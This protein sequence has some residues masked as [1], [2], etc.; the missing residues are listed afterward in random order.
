MHKTILAAAAALGLVASAHAEPQEAWIYAG[1]QGGAMGWEASSIKR[2]E[3]AGTA[4][5][6][7]FFY[8]TKP[9]DGAKG[10]FSWAFQ[11][12][13]FDCVEN[14]FRLM[15]GAF[16]NK[17]RRGRSDQKASKDAFPVRD[18]TPEYVLKKVVCD[19]AVLSGSAAASSMADA[20]DG[21]ERLS[22]GWN[23]AASRGDSEPS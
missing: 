8:F 20:M 13:E 4:S 21:A 16:F 17:A 23:T 2:D 22:K 1:M 3:S 5:A 19:S 14:T 12:I 10:D 9:E 11:N 6:L 7:R 15:D 18:N